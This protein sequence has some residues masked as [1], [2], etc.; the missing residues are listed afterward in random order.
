MVHDRPGAREALQLFVA[1]A[2]GPVVAAVR[3][4]VACVL[5]EALE[6]VNTVG[7]EVWPTTVPL[8]VAQLAPTQEMVIPG[9]A[10]AI[11]ITVWDVDDTVP[12]VTVMVAE[13]LSAMVGEKVTTT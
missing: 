6:T 1:I 4:P 12:S 13:A 7:D 8:K 9:R 2:K 11:P 3:V 5:L 10:R